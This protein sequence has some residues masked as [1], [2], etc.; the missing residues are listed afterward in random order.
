METIKDL[1]KQCLNNIIYAY[2]NNLVSSGNVKA[3]LK[4]CEL[5]NFGEYYEVNF[6]KSPIISRKL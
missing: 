4:L 1:Y 5:P 3:L 2:K 6:C